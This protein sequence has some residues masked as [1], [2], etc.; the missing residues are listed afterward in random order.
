LVVIQTLARC[1]TH[2]AAPLVPGG[3]SA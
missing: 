2:R 3:P 1:G